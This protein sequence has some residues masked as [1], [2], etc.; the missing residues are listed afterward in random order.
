[1]DE[2]EDQQV[3]PRFPSL[4]QPWQDDR[5]PKIYEL[6]IQFIKIS[7][8]LGRILQGLHSPRGKSFSALH[9]SDG[10]VTRLD[11]ELTEWRFG[12]PAALK[13]AQIPDF[14]EI[15]GYF[16]PTIGNVLWGRK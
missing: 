7:E 10:L 9:G 12:F 11:H 2:L 1:M 14:N 6:F 5:R 8:I 15:S 3:A 4:A 13:D 16:A